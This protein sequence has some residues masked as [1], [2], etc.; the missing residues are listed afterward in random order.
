MRRRIV[1]VIVTVLGLVAIALAV[2]SATIWRPS[3][4]VEATLASSPT[5][6]Y[7]VT[8]P[9]VLGTVSSE[10]TVEASAPGD[11]EVTVI[12]ARA[13]DVQAWLDEDPY[14]SVTGLAE[15]SETL[16]STDVT[17]VCGDE[18]SSQDADQTA[19]PTQGASADASAQASVQESGCV[20]RE[21]T[22][23][24]P[25]GSD[26]WIDEHTGTSSVSFT[27]S[28]TNAH[29]V[30]LAVT[31]G[32]EAAPTLTLSW[33]RTVSTPWYFYAGLVVGGLLVLVG[34][35]LFLIDIQM[36]HADRRR[37]SQAAEKAAR[38]AVADEVTTAGLPRLDDP[39]RKL[40]RREQ[41]DKERAE[42]AGLEWVDPRTGR[43]H[44]NGVEVPD[45]PGAQEAWG[46][47]DAGQPS[48]QPGDAA[49][50]P[51]VPG[52]TEAVSGY[53]DGQAWGGQAVAGVDE[54][55]G[56][57]SVGSG[58]ETV[59]VPAVPDAGSADVAGAGPDLDPVGAP[60]AGVDVEAE[61]E[62]GPWTSSTSRFAPPGAGAFQPAPGAAVPAP[63][64]EA[65]GEA[66]DVSAFTFDP[67]AVPGAVPPQA[68]QSQDAVGPVTQ[69]DAPQAWGQAVQDSAPEPWKQAVPGQ[70]P[71]SPPMPATV[72]DLPQDQRQEQEYQGQ[73]EP[74]QV[75]GQPQ[76]WDWS[77]EPGM[78]GWPGREGSGSQVSQVPQDPQVPQDSYV[79][80]YGQPQ[81]S[82]VSYGQPPRELSLPEP[83]PEQQA[84]WGP[85]PV[86]QE[87][88]PQGEGALPG[89]QPWQL[90]PLGT[91]QQAEPDAASG[92]V[93]PETGPGRP[94]A[95]AM[96]APLP[97][98]TGPQAEAEDPA[99]TAE[100]AAVQA[101][102]VAP[103]SD[104][105]APNHEEQA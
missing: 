104:E 8:E 49:G 23:S 11:S 72:P 14:V 32:Q 65:G 54:V 57:A 100:V 66:A 78:W 13:A 24:N 75:P 42:A 70:E 55:A 10:V 47:Q 61:A 62:T 2:C 67:A 76:T 88:Q 26:L 7:L 63:G 16:E 45:V 21:A 89:A 96:K 102:P 48:E 68:P 86:T 83:S 91:G 15:G 43:V 80:P 39:S 52:S 37:R 36:R 41:R 85:E 29:N 6:P 69:E 71:V 50:L 18:A 40:T 38:I 98:M 5:Q 82:Q 60:D 27:Y 30:I 1:S 20:P 34:V 84:G 4:T 99:V 9:G 56:G 92:Q 46:A 87:W 64:E 44:V 59:V 81:Q 58:E 51:G 101:E 25:V 93:V 3:P 33:P 79:P 77:P 35:F 17:E 53:W 31:D 73:Q 28:A 94:E 19:E 90:S 95:R 12:V 22:G 103:S 74:G 105:A 97:S